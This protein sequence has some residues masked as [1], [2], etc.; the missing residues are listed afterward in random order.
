MFIKRK[1]RAGNAYAYRMLPS[2]KTS[3]TYCVH[4]DAFSSEIAQFVARHCPIAGANIQTC[5]EGPKKRRFLKNDFQKTALQE[6]I[7]LRLQPETNVT[8][9]NFSPL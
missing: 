1:T 3:V 9:E 4:C 7:T 5:Y 8:Y 6:Y 2:F